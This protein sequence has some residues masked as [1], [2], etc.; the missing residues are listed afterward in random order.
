MIQNNHDTS[1]N[2]DHVRWIGGSPCAG[3]STLSNLLINRFPLTLYSCDDFFDQHCSELAATTE[4]CQ[5]ILQGSHPERLVLPVNAQVELEFAAYREQFALIQRDIASM[6]SPVLAEGAALLPELFAGQ[7]IPQSHA[8]WIVPTEAFQRTMYRQRDW[9]W[10]MLA[11]APDP[12]RLFDR[13]M[14]RDAEFSRM[15]ARQARELGYRVITVDGTRPVEAILREVIEHFGLS[16][17]SA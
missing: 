13:W 1:R 11:S 3:K 14:Q 9:A 16:H 10:S 5:S 2:L 15:V 7:N 17:S 6:G 8:V 4:I 12:E